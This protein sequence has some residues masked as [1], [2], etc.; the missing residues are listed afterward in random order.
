MS[1]K[2][3][4]FSAVKNIFSFLLFFIFKYFSAIRTEG[5]IFFRIFFLLFLSHI[6]CLFIQS[7]MNGLLNRITSDLSQGYGD[8]YCQFKKK[9][10]LKDFENKK[11]IER[12]KKN[13]M[14][15]SCFFYGMVEGLVF[16]GNQHIPVIVLTFL[17]DKQ[18]TIF[19][20]NRFDRFDFTKK[21]PY[22]GITLFNKLSS[23]EE[24]IKLAIITEQNEKKNCLFYD[25]MP[26]K[27]LEK[28][29]FSWD[30]WNE[31]ALVFNIVNFENYFE[32]P[33]I[34][35]INIYLKDEKEQQSVCDFLTQEFKDELAFISASV[36]MFPEHHRYLNLIKFISG[37]VLYLIAIFSMGTLSILIE[38]YVMQH[39]MEY[40]Y[41]RMLG[42][43][44]YFIILVNI[45]FL[46]SINI[47][48]FVF[49]TGFFFI[50]RKFL[51]FFNLLTIDDLT[52]T[53]LYLDISSFF[54]F[55]YFLSSL[56][57]NF[58]VSFLFLKKHIK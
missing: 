26:I 3:I 36:D 39:S 29:I 12:I 30:E 41:L 28:S 16:A 33:S 31:R 15:Q 45:I 9:L 7:I 24:K 27:H 40:L 18:D 38:L 55:F 20:Y 48:S 21:P 51:Y 46:L 22:A 4:S 50:F 43:K 23:V 42:L 25:V 57:L 11:I 13:T 10:F 54:Y 6:F 5:R 44:K 56:F 1:L 58:C 34:L 47:L 14:I 32:V 37:F 52:H 8:I 17:F 49:S 53:V 35:G 2:K 19:S